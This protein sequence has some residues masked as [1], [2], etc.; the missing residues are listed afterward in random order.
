MHVEWANRSI[1]Q[2]HNHHKQVDQ[3]TTI[4]GS[5]HDWWIIEI[6]NCICMIMCFRVTHTSKSSAIHH[7]VLDWSCSC[8]D[9]WL[10]YA[11]DYVRYA[12]VDVLDCMC[13]R[14]LRP[15]RVIPSE[16]YPKV[17]R[18]PCAIM[19]KCEQCNVMHMFACTRSLH[20]QHMSESVYGRVSYRRI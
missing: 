13:N 9:A 4:V 10:S 6:E 17:L 12:W 1:T 5:M 2:T 18:G 15:C 7:I 8:N 14:H 11:I 20:T 3:S 19:S 16:L